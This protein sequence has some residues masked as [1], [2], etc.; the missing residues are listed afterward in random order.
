[1]C[2]IA[3]FSGDFERSL[4]ERMNDAIA[5]RGPDDAGACW[6]PEDRLGLAHRRL[7]II[8][9]SPRGHQPMWDATGTAAIV[10]NGEIYNYRE[11]RRE[12]VADGFAFN[13]DC[14]TEVLLN[15]F[16]RDGDKMLTRLNGIFAFALWDSRSKSLLLAR[17][18]VGVKPLYYAETAQGTLFASELKAL[19]NE[20]SVDR[21]LNHQAVYHH[22]VYLWCPSPL[23]M[24]ESV[25]KLEPGHALRVKA[26]RVVDHFEFYDLP[27]DQELVEWPEQDAIV[28][29]RKYLRRAVERQLV[30]DVPVGAFL[31]GGPILDRSLL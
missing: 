12:L 24:L 22:L 6:L 10:Y 16:L 25:K 20:P 2:G 4:L 13:S 26:G 30:S 14:D 21:T 8:D 19:L 5:H 17:D 31:S 7:S 18:G 23:T 15:L 28:Q 9:L 3:G 27:F 1:M 11:L 29:V